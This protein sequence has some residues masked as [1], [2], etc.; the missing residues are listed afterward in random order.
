MCRYKPAVGKQRFDVCPTQASET[1]IPKR[2]VLHHASGFTYPSIQKVFTL[3][4]DCSYWQPFP[5]WASGPHHGEALHKL[6]KEGKFP[7]I[8]DGVNFYNV[9]HEFVQKWVHAFFASEEVLRADK[10][11]SGFYAVL[12]KQ[13]SQFAYKLPEELNRKNLV[14]AVSQFIF[15]VTGFH[16]VCDA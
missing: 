11:L 16:Q 14:N 2:S 1:L 12:A 5:E 7:F 3:A 10:R 15:I 4:K 8:N 13:T 6:V 9:V